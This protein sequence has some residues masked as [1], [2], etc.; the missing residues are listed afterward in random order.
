MKI[1][2]F[3]SVAS[4]LDTSTLDNEIKAKIDEIKYLVTRLGN[5]LTNKEK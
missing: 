1:I 3:F 2:K 5:L 4:D